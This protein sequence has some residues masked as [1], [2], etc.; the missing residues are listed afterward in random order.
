MGDEEEA[1]DKIIL[2]N[3]LRA[4]GD[5]IMS[6]RERASILSLAFSCLIDHVYE[7]EMSMDCM[8]A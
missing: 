2:F 7:H 4:Y 1:K 3:L 8:H 6:T 5:C